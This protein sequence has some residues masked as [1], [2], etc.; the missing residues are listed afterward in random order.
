V[1]CGLEKTALLG[2][3]FAIELNES[4]VHRRPKKSSVNMAF[5]RNLAR[6]RTLNSI[7]EFDT[8]D[9]GLKDS[10]LNFA[11]S[12]REAKFFNCFEI[13]EDYFTMRV[14]GS[15][16]NRTDHER[17]KSII[18][19]KPLLFHDTSKIKFHLESCSDLKKH[20]HIK[21]SYCNEQKYNSEEKRNS[22]KNGDCRYDHAMNDSESSSYVNIYKSQGSMDS[23]IS[24]VS[25]D[26]V[27]KSPRGREGE[28]SEP[29]SEEEV[30]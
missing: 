28:M 3:S 19:P 9:T 27:M 18:I 15:K 11:K 7:L 10:M 1:I 16:K 23:Y 24:S 13:R 25:L 14:R 22:E 12:P 17:S 2:G 8:T 30:L 29:L 6:Q 5:H 20:V 26:I 4:E 21:G